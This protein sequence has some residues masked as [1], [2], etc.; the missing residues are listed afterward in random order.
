MKP[1]NW[2]ALVVAIVA[3]AASIW[4]GY[5]QVQAKG[6]LPGSLAEGQK[7]CTVTVLG[8]FATS[9]LVPRT[10]SSAV[11]RSMVAQLADPN[12]PNS[13]F[14]LGVHSLMEQSLDRLVGR[15]LRETAVGEVL[16]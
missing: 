6:E 15:R 7:I 1:E 5:L 13:T 8:S 16:R 12:N 4:V 14:R 2:V 3:A 9:L 11:C 10:W